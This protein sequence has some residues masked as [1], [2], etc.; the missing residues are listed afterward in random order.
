MLKKNGIPFYLQIKDLLK[1]EIQTNYKVNELIPSEKEL[2]KKYEVSRI[3]IRKA[4]EEL[5][6]ENIVQKK[7][8]K[9]TFV[10]E[11]K[12]S[13]DANYVGSLTQR[14]AKKNLILET[15]SIFFEIIEDDNHFVKKLLNTKHLLCIKRV[16]YLKDTPFALMINYFDLDLVP[17]IDKKFN[18]ESLYEFIKKEYDIELFSAQETIEA[19]PASKNQALQ[20]SV[21]ENFPLLSLKRLSFDKNEI[22][23]EY[24]NLIIKSDMYQHK[25]NLVTKNKS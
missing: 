2:E 22:P 14:L 23:I 17:Q 13:Y 18:N 11:Q 4:I 24:S 9:G 21:N 25:I 7:Q 12:I 3:T 8:G 1:K 15:K 20:L 19:I 16:K 5:E 6:K 10:Q